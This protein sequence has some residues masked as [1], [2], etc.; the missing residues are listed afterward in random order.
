MRNL[1]SLNVS[2]PISQAIKNVIGWRKFPKQQKPGMV[3]NL[4][5]GRLVKKAYP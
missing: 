4:M 5:L 1:C 2:F 3:I